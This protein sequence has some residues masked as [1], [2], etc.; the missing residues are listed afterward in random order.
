MGGRSIQFPCGSGHSTGV[1][2]GV[3][4]HLGCELTFNVLMTRFVVA[5][6]LLLA[7]CTASTPQAQGSP[8]PP[9]STSPT[10]DDL[11]K[12]AAQMYPFEGGRYVTC[13]N[14]YGG[15]ARYSHC[16][17]T[18]RLNDRLTTVFSGLISA[19]EP[20]GGAQDPEWATESI[21]ADLGGTGGVAHVVLTKPGSASSRY[22]LVIVKS[23]GTLLVDDVYCT[24]A[25]PAISSIYVAGWMNRFSC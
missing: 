19:P 5:G 23:E 22:D 1:R 10:A 13:D 18:A 20:L 24:Q 8:S 7:A 2:R 3:G 9:S 25:D 6:L 12:V 15:S 14:G 4:R 11:V 21:T 17:V 16:P